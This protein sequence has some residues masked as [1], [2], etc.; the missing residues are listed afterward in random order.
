MLYDVPNPRHVVCLKVFAIWCVSSF[1]EARASGLSKVDKEN[2]SIV[3]VDWIQRCFES[4]N[5]FIGSISYRTS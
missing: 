3:T 4:C 2:V 5:V 1:G